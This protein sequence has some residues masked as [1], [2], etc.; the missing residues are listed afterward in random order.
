MRG[1]YAIVDL[2]A[3]TAAGIDP[4]VFARAVL[5]V[6]PAALQLRAKNCPSR[7]TL[8]LL[9]ALAPLCRRFG[10]P[11]VAN[12]RS[13]LAMLGGIDIVHLGQDDV[14]IELVRRLTPGLKVGLSTHTPEQITR[15]LEHRPDYVA[16]GPVFATQTKTN[17]AEVVG[18]AGLQAAA[19]IV[20]AH[21]GGIPLVAIGGIDLERAARVG[22]LAHCGAVI[23]HLVG[24][25][26]SELEIAR[27][28]RA[29][30]VALGGAAPMPALSVSP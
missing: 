12:D 23:A 15:A 2:A 21:G 30:H 1:L 27:R 25:G 29:L 9:R 20:A 3:L 22:A 14:P 10:V 19:A 6:R 16:Y 5:S 18:L 28:A 26:S 17:A 11:L 4:L 7:E 8:A 24:G 13:D